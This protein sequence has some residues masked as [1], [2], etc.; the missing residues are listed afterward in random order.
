MEFWAEVGGAVTRD[1]FLDD[2][3][4]YLEDLDDDSVA[5]GVFTS[6]PDISEVPEITTGYQEA[7]RFAVY[8]DWFTDVAAL[9]FRK[10]ADQSWAIFLQ[11]DVRVIYQHHSQLDH[12]MDKSHL[13]SRAADREGCKLMWHKICTRSGRSNN[14]SM[15]RPQVRFCVQV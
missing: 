8:K 14:V 13:L 10:L 1:V 5:S 2:A 11:S 15:G 4:M 3:I 6:L 7:D 12:W 9:I